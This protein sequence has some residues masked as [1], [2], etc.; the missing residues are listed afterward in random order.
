MFSVAVKLAGFL[1][2]NGR[3]YFSA[4]PPTT[5]YSTPPSSSIEEQ[6]PQSSLSVF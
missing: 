4:A 5:N 3:E 6:H 1:P 2:V